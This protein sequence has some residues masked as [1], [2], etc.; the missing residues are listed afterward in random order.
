MGAGALLFAAPA[1]AAFDPNA[2][3]GGIALPDT[4]VLYND[5]APPRPTYTPPAAS[6]EYATPLPPVS[7]PARPLYPGR[8]ATMEAGAPVPQPL[9]A[10]DGGGFI[11]P[12]PLV[13][14]QPAP[15]TPGSAVVYAPTPVGP[16]V[17]V[18]PMAEVPPGPAVAVAQG[19]PAPR[20]TLTPQTRAILSE[21]PSRIDTPAP[22]SG[23]N[24][25]LDRVSPEIQQLLG[26]GE[27][28]EKFQSV[29]LSIAVRRPGLDTNYE[30]NRAYTALMGNDTQ[31][32]I[33]VY[34]NILSVDPQN[35]DALFGL[36]ATYHRLGEI[37]KARPL[38]GMLLKINPNHREGLN[39]FL[40]LVADESPADALPELER[41]EQRNPD[42]SPIPAQ[43]GLVMD[44]LGYQEQARQQLLRAIE[45]APDNL[46]YKYN[47]AV[48]L[49]RQGQ[50]ADAGSLYRLLITASLHGETV[51]A[52]LPV[53]QKRLNYISTLAAAYVAPG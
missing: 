20:S 50:Y 34:K 4:T 25:A 14:V 44:K 40:A 12:A 35:Q 3:A 26:P 43:L 8:S 33:E 42:F 52:P 10:P 46:T 19:P 47:L 6:P 1:L 30:L 16:P 27:K 29:G 2:G 49:D 53:L 48:M 32:A 39:N 41:L 13:A 11:A 9:P 51:P 31:T 22:P 23:G 15:A 18:V 17:P 24:I 5:G 37:D 7:M 45:L 28:E 21:I 36:A 38:Y